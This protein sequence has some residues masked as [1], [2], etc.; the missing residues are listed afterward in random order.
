MK[1]MGIFGMGKFF[2][3]LC[4]LMSAMLFVGICASQGMGA[5][6]AYDQTGYDY[7]GSPVINGEQTAPAL[8]DYLSPYSGQ[9][10]EWDPYGPGASPQILGTPEWDPFGSGMNAFQLQ[11]EPADPARE[12]L[13]VSGSERLANL[14]Y[15][16]RGQELSTQG[17]VSLGE[18]YVLWARVNG[19]GSLRLYDYGRQILNQGY[20][21]PGWYKITGAYAD[22][23]G[24]H[25]YRFVSAGLASNNLSILVDSGGYPT[26]LSLTGRV[27]DQSGQGM[28]G[29]RVIASNNEGGK[30]STMTGFGGYYAIDVPTGIYLVNA[31]Y[32]GYVFAPSSAHAITGTVSAARPIVGAIN[33]SPAPSA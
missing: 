25:I 4:G 29:V 12:G 20:V 13:T 33:G 14:L 18:A 27:L 9:R 7:M 16:Q 11:I 6:K 3:I 22:F 31:E 30:F 8:P 23:M 28:P 21:T 32:P 19:R 2:I 10:P 17:A 5:S 1:S 24:N 26:S 15:V